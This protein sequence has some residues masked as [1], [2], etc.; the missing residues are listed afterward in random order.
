MITLNVQAFKRLHDGFASLA[1]N[2][3]SFG[4]KTILGLLRSA[5]DLT[6][7]LR[8][9]KSRFTVDKGEDPFPEA[10]FANAWKTD[11]DELLPV[12]GKDEIYDEVLQEMSELE[13]S[14]DSQLRKFEK[15]LGYAQV[16]NN[17]NI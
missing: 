2:S 7:H 13:Q 8:D 14:L 9:I 4:S 15:K 12:D 6:S 16:Y 5:P 17:C 10:L 1:E 11:T 3:E